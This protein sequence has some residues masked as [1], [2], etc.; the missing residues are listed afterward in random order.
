MKKNGGRFVPLLILMT[1]LFGLSFIATKQALNGLGIFQVV[2][3][4]HIIALLPLTLILWRDKEMFFIAPG[5]RWPLL[6]LTF[7]EPVGYFIFETFGLRYTS[8]ALVSIIIATIPVFSLVFAYWILDEKV[9][10]IA[11]LG[12]FLSLLGVYGVV[13]IQQKSA[14]APL[15]LLGNILALGA[16]ISAGFYNVLCRKLTQSYSPW[17]ITFYQAVVASIVFLPLTFFEGGISNIVGWNKSVLISILYLSLG[18]S[19][20]A[21]YLLNYSLRHLPTHKVAIFANLI[22]VVTVFW[23]WVIYGEW[24]GLRQLLGAL[25]VILGVYLT[26]YRFKRKKISDKNTSVY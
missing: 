11:L 21:Y 3:F 26:Y 17:T 24:L 6:I 1:C 7:V 23:S 22:P 13:S 16:A 14:L 4:R 5:D 8:P 25:V 15:P 19:V 10:L 9:N 2:F 18:S 20:L 12:I